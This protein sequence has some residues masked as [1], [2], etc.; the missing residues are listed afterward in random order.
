M[1]TYVYFALH[2]HHLHHPQ[3]PLS[4]KALLK[5]SLKQFDSLLVR[6]SSF[7]AD[8]VAGHIWEGSRKETVQLLLEFFGC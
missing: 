2:S 3:F 5:V 4:I 1:I 7:D 8:T 6:V